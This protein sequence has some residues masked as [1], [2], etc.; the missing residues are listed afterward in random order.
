MK[1][2]RINIYL[3]FLFLFLSVITYG[4][5]IKIGSASHFIVNGNPTVEIR[6]GSFINNG[7]FNCGNGRFY[8]TGDTGTAYMKIAGTNAITFYDLEIRKALNDIF[9]QRNINVLNN[10]KFNK[11][12]ILLNKFTI[13]LAGTGLLINENNLSRIAEFDTI[14]SSV[15]KVIATALLSNPSAANPGNLGLYITSIENL[16]N[17]IVMRGHVRVLDSPYDGIY[18]FYDITPD[19]NN[20]LEATIKFSY[21]DGEDKDHYETINQIFDSLNASQPWQLRGYDVRDITDNFIEVDSI[22]SLGRITLAHA[23]LQLY[24]GNVAT[25]IC[26]GTPVDVPFTTLLVHDTSNTFNAQLS[27][28]KGLF[29]NPVIIGSLHGTQSDTIHAL[30]P[31]STAGGVNYR[32]RVVSSSQSANG[33]NNGQNIKIDPSLLFYVDRDQ[34]GFGRSDSS[35]YFCEPTGIYTTPV[36]GDCNDNDPNVT[37][38]VFYYADYDNDGHGFGGT[39]TETLNESFDNVSSI[40]NNGWSQLNNS[41]PVGPGTWDQGSGNLFNAFSGGINSYVAVGNNSGSGMSDIKNWLFSPVLNIANGSVINFRTRTYNYPSTTPDQLQVRVSTNGNSTQPADFSGVLL[42]IN[43]SLKTTGYPGIWTEYTVQVAGLTSSGSGRIAFYYKV[44]NGGPLGNNSYYI[45][46]DDVVFT[47]K[48]NRVFAECSAPPPNFVLLNDDCNDS[49]ATVYPGAVEYCNGLDDNCDGIAENNLAP[50]FTGLVAHYS[51]D[52]NIQ[53]ISGNGNDAISATNIIYPSP[54]VCSSPSFASFGAASDVRIPRSVSDD[55]TVSF[56]FKTNQTAV[57]GTHFYEGISLINAEVCGASNDWGISLIDGGK[58]CFGVGNIDFTIKSPLANYNNNAWHHVA[59]ERKRSNGDMR[60]YIDGI[61]VSSGLSTNTNSLNGPAVIGFGRN[62]CTLANYTGSLDEV[63]LYTRLLDSIEVR[64]LSTCNSN[65]TFYPD[66]DGD[67][68]G[69]PGSIALTDDGTSFLTS[70]GNGWTVVNNS[71][72]IGA[73]TWSQGNSSV[74]SANSPPA[75]SYFKVDYNSGSALSTISNWLILPV[76]DIKDGSVLTFKTR[77][78]STQYPDR[79]QVWLS[80]NGNSSNVGTTA[81]STGDFNQLLL[82]INPGLTSSG[83]PTTWTPYTIN[84]SGYPAA[85]QGR[86]AFRYYVPNGGPAGANSAYIGIDDISYSSSNTQF[87]FCTQPAGYVANALDCNDGNPQINFAANEI[88]C[89]NVDE[90]CN[91]VADDFNALQLDGVNDYVRIP[92]SATLNTSVFTFEAWVYPQGNAGTYRAVVSNRDDTGFGLNTR[93]FMLYASPGNFWEFWTGKGTGTSPGNYWN[94][95]VTTVPV[96]LNQWAHVAI[97]YDGTTKRIYINGVLSGFEIVPY[98]L[99]SQWP[100]Y[101]GAGGNDFVNPIAPQYFFN[102]KIDEA[103]FWNVAR[104][105]TDIQNSMNNYIPTS[106]ANLV[107]YYNFDKGT[108][109]GNNN[110]VTELNDVTPNGN[111]GTLTNF[112]LTGAT[113]NWV[114]GIT[115]A[116]YPDADGD[117]VGSNSNIL[118]S[119]CT[120]AG[121][122]LTSG[123]CD[124]TNAAIKPGAIEICGNFIDDNCNG[125]IDENNSLSF[126]GNNDFVSL[127]STG[128][129]TANDFTMEAWVYPTATKT[130]YRVFDFGTSNANYIMM[131]ASNG[132]TMRPRVGIKSTSLAEQ[133]LDAPSAILLNAWTHLAFTLSG[134]T[135]KLYVNGNL[136]VTNNAVTIHPINVG[137]TTNNWL[138]KSQFTGDSLFTGRIDEARVWTVARTQ[139]EIQ[140]SMFQDF[141]GPQTGLTAYYKFDQG[142]AGASNTGVN[143]LTDISGNNR[144]GTLTNFALNGATSNWVAG[145]SRIFYKDQDGDGFGNPLSTLNSFCQPSGY[146]SDNTD[147]DDSNAL[148]FGSAPFTINCPANIV[149]NV[150]SGHCTDTIAIPPP[151]YGVSC[152]YGAPGTLAFDG[153]NDYASVSSAA[154]LSGTFTVEAW[155]KPA[156]PTKKMTVIGSRGGPSD[157]SFDFKFEGGNKIHGDI[158][159]GTAWLTTV[160]DANFN[161]VAGTWY[162]IAYVVTPTN[163]KIYINGVLAANVN[164]SGG[165]PLLY[166]SSHLLT[167]G[168]PGSTYNLEH[169]EGQ[170]DEVRVWNTARTQTDI[171]NNRGIALSGSEPGLVR[172]YRLNDATGTVMKDNS[173]SAVNGTLSNFSLSGATSNWTANSALVQINNNFNNTSNATGV[174]PAGTTSVIWTATTLSSAVNCTQTIT[175]NPPL[176]YRDADNDSYGNPSDTLRACIK[177]FGYV[178]DSTDCNDAN[179]LVNTPKLFYLDNDSDGFGSNII[180]YSCSS[181]APPGAADNNSDCDDARLLY[182]DIDKDGYGNPTS[183]ACGVV[184]NN[185]CNDNN[186]GISPGNTESYCNGVDENCNGLVDEGNNFSVSVASTTNACGNLPNGSIQLTISDAIG[187]INTIIDTI[188]ADQVFSF[189]S[190]YGNGIN[191]WSVNDILGAPNTYPAYGDIPTAWASN[192]QDNQRE[193]LELG[194][195]SSKIATEILIYETYAPGAIDTVYIRDAASGQWMNIYTNTAVAQSPVS[196][197]LKIPVTYSMYINGVRIAIN[198]PDVYDWNEIDAV[199]IIGTAGIFNGAQSIG[200]APPGFTTYT[201][202]NGNGCSDTTLAFIQTDAPFISYADLDGDTYG[203]SLNTVNLCNIPSGYVA[204]ADDCDDNNFSLF[205]KY[206]YYLDADSDGFGTGTQIALCDN[207]APSGYSVF[208]T[209]CNDNDP[210]I[211]ALILY[212][213]DNDDD[214][215]GSIDTVIPALFCSAVAPTGYVT[216]SS[217]CNDFAILYLD[218]DADGYG[219]NDTVACGV[220]NNIDCNDNDNTVFYPNTFYRDNDNDGLGDAAIYTLSCDAVLNGY[221]LNNL[222]CNDN[223][224]LLLLAYTFYGDMDGDLFGDRNNDSV[225]CSLTPPPGYVANSNDCNDANPLL[226]VFIDYYADIDGDLYGDPFNVYSECSAIPPH[227]VIY[228]TDTLNQIIDSLVFDC[229]ANNL[230]CNDTNATVFTQHF[231]YLDNDGDGF[232]SQMALILCDTIAPVGYV[233]DSTDC[234]DNS[235]MYVDADNDGYGGTLQVACGVLNSIDCDD[236]NASIQQYIYYLDAD[237]DG[238]GSL[239]SILT[240][241]INPPPGYVADSTDCN[242]YAMLFEDKDND[243]YGAD[244]IPVACGSENALD[245]NDFD[246]L[247]TRYIYYL[248]GDDD[249]FGSINSIAICDTSPPAGYVINNSDCNDAEPSFADNDGDSFGAGVYIPCGV[250]DSTDCDD[251]DSL[252]TFNIY[253]LD[254][255]G[256]GFGSTSFIRSCAPLPP[257]GYS[258][259]SLDCNDLLLT[260]T[261]ND[262][263]GFGAGLPIVCGVDN[264]LDCNDND[265]TLTLIRT[266]YIDTDGDG[267]GSSDSSFQVCNHL[268]YPGFV[269]NNDDCNDNQLLYADLDNDGFGGDTAAC[270]LTSSLDCNDRDSLIN[271]STAEYNCNFIDDNCDGFVDEGNPLSIVVSA[272]QNASAG[273]FNGQISLSVNGGTGVYDLASVLKYADNVVGYSSQIGSAVGTGSALDALGLPNVYPLYGMNDSAW[274]TSLPDNGRAYLEVGFHPPLSIGG[275]SVYQ[276]FNSGAIDTVYVRSA[277]NQSWHILYQDSVKPLADTIIPFSVILSVTGILNF[278]IDAVRLSINSDSVPGFNSIDAIGVLFKNA[279]YNGSAITGLPSGKHEITFIDTTTKCLVDFSTEIGFNGIATWYQDNDND[280]YGNFSV[281]ISALVKPLGYVAISGDC[282][283]NNAFVNPSMLEAPCNS[284]DDDCDGVSDENNALHFDGTSNYVSTHNDVVLD[285]SSSFTIQVYAKRMELTVDTIDNALISHGVG[286][287]NKGIFIGFMDSTNQ[288]VFSVYN[289]NDLILPDQYTDTLWHLWTCVYNYSSSIVDRYVYRDGVLIG[290]VSDTSLYSGVGAI[291]IGSSFT[292]GNGSYFAGIIDEV[293]VWKKALT[294]QEILSG[295]GSE[296]VVPATGLTNHFNFNDGIAGGNNTTVNITFDNAIING[297][298]E[299]FYFTLNGTASNFV[300]GVSSVLYPDIDQDGYYAATAGSV[301]GFCIPSSYAATPGDCNDTIALINP[302]MSEV[303]GNS[304]DDNCNAVIDEGCNGNLSFNLRASIEGYA[305]PGAMLQPAL[306]NTGITTN[307]NISDTVIVELRDQFS[308]SVVISTDIALLTIN[309]LA[310]VNYPPAIIGGTY[311]IVIRQRNSIA[312]WSNLPVTFSGSPVFYDF[313]AP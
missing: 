277:L 275:A 89:N 309:G 85:V 122:I 140:N 193:F 56:W 235:I 278:P 24:T 141:V 145:I 149:N 39:G 8:F 47:E 204:N 186:S 27:D 203:D 267:F 12:N 220:S 25:T 105:Q 52:I 57:N 290:T 226:T 259:D 103:R 187:S 17:T 170:I 237:N 135:G 291:R 161:Y 190:Q 223:D 150:A 84:I 177:P 82:D 42:V 100:V 139:T 306:F 30:I 138:G 269:L 50:T 185:D 69:V 120:P 168:R 311:W 164:I 79:L 293:S 51:L 312:T 20:N 304:I 98:F 107:A 31:L 173:T 160:A 146:V 124:D 227:I 196:G 199:G 18:R 78:R 280:G 48:S 256:D 286:L 109:N 64:I 297:Y 213:A 49:I 90:N 221:V 91:G 108:A 15:G 148:I 261:D 264:N 189:S 152:L 70:L 251:T 307:P 136:V 271:P 210:L 300:Q 218:F 11:G 71:S 265:S 114:S 289:S 246:S 263:D 23:D 234:N 61:L 169:F 294:Q 65:V 129:T 92:Y 276:T 183:V 156:H 63:Q 236:S 158:G 233:A 3:V 206:Y 1:I 266:F 54:G 268:M 208:N 163:Y 142:V 197:I 151:T 302:N 80:T 76:E 28:D 181:I 102:G 179:A 143:T 253:Y 308:P 88:V 174:Y 74:F 21:F 288:F 32:I 115:R 73:Q 111:P 44:D 283:D 240:C 5:G 157:P 195:T 202:I 255:D 247:I 154:T 182:E 175:V 144:T 225:T 167:I 112:G 224:P 26:A 241:L 68:F 184:D 29:G 134:N 41:S 9:L 178:P 137:A 215:F 310:T 301:S 258:I 116:W 87:A 238:F 95:I 284:M 127:S 244:S 16:G 101:I 216:D 38:A 287:S 166:N 279:V 125:Q 121:Y 62:G 252:V 313:T 75:D 45:G 118:N 260:Y 194:F 7:N 242:D 104:S 113:S 281:S 6:N 201:F 207:V 270:G 130:W 72:P 110:G 99:N 219:S 229:V 117:S 254:N 217:D 81:T 200:S 128:L 4:Q 83:Y 273:N 86:L 285:D 222:D 153:V 171:Q 296:T 119:F 94:V 243:G 126:D 191:S 66:A 188:W 257:P 106:Q 35:A 123:D 14:Y 292:S 131:A 274:S 59:A 93:G 209:D 55:F 230:D 53:D 262:L 13:D 245:C 232:G 239:N 250:S 46:I 36:G 58:V 192:S 147:C 96:V 231:F 212:Y 305:I 205:T 165:T 155:A 176:W 299:L 133:T 97:S 2:S 43:D 249:G 34:D 132:V 180:V 77:T 22:N 298:G 198:S 19:F 60:L 162:H 10:I 159:T 272:V 33:T 214:G 211:N 37:N 228:I 248:D 282:N 67:G 172:Y 303:C 40:Y 295:L